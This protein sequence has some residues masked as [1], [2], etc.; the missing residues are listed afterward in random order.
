MENKM[1]ACSTEKFI[2]DLIVAT[3]G[4]DSSM[5]EQY[6]LRQALLGLV[7]Q[8]KIEQR[9]EIRSSVARMTGLS[10]GVGSRRYTKALLRD[11]ASR[12]NGPQQQ[13]EFDKGDDR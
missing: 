12:T 3:K 6:L 10:A 5:R 9:V 1:R 4:A 2:E 13:F 11:I 8:A 7:R